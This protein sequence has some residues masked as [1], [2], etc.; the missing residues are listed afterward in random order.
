MESISSVHIIEEVNAPDVQQTFDAKIQVPQEITAND[1]NVDV[2]SSYSSDN[3]ETLHSELL[4]LCNQIENVNGSNSSSEKNFNHQ[5][6]K[7]LSSKVS[8]E[9]N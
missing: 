9:W 7:K 6:K 4:E 1:K 5:A 2:A 8:C 3:D